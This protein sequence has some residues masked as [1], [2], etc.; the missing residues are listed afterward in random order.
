MK[1]VFFLSLTLIILTL[2]SCQQEN[3]LDETKSNVNE[4]STNNKEGRICL[5]KFPPSLTGQENKG[6]V[7]QQ[8]KWSNGQTVRVKFLNGDGFLQQKVRQFASEWMNYANI[9][10]VFV[11]ANENAEIKIN[12]DNSNASWSYYG[13]YSQNIAQNQASMNFGWFNGST[14][15]AE[16]SRTT[17]HEFGH[18]LGMVH[19]HQNPNVT[20]PWNRP[21]VY[22]YFAGAPNYWSAQQVDNNILNTFSPSETNSGS[23]DRASI[24]HYFFPNGLTLDGSTFTQNN[25]L[26]PEDKSFIGQIYP[27]TTVT[28]RSIL[29]SN[30]VLYVN[31]YIVSPNGRFK[32]IMQGDGNLVV[33]QDDSTPLWSSNTYGTPVDRCIMQGDGNLV[34][35]SSNSTPYWSIGYQSAG[36][37]LV[38]QDDGNLVVYNNGSAIWSWMSGLLM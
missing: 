35:Y 16:F 17:I 26:S 34:L 14:P 30:E 32:C 38:M 27:F 24:M 33:Y 20:I 28:S 5:D 36:A 13:N 8:Y 1:K 4:Q 11:S 21:A 23:Y 7:L 12:F 29:N 22:A 31:E 9:N 6:S 2:W 10:F 15:D 37:Y 3:V 19:E 18:A 25:V